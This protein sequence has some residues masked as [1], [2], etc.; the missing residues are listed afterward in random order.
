MIFVIVSNQTASSPFCL[1]R[2]ACFCFIDRWLVLSFKRE[3]PYG[4][5]LTMFEIISSQH[6]E[7]SSMEAERERSR[8]RAKELEKDGKSQPLAGEIGRAHV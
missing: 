4:D 5:A 7:L 6:L 3:F 1:C 2:T 8:Q